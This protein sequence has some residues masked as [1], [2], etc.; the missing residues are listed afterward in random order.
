MNEMLGGNRLIMAVVT[1]FAVSIVLWV[2]GFGAGL[3][4]KI[5]TDITTSDNI[6]IPADLDQAYN[7]G[8]KYTG[9]GG[10]LAIYVVILML[11]ITFFGVIFGMFYGGLGGARVPSI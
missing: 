4:N 1:I 10:R 11:V 2:L 3:F 8:I 6:T 9:L 7:T 5:Q